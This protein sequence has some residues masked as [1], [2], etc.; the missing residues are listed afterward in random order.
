MSAESYFKEASRILEQVVSTQMGK[1][2]EAAQVLA[3][4]VANGQSIFSFGAS[5]SFILTEEIVYRAGGLMLVNPIYPHG[6]NLFIRPLTLTSRLERT[7][8]LGV[9]LLQSS[10]ARPG[11]VLIIAS[12]S[13][14]NAV[15]VD[16]ALTAVEKKIRTIGIT[17][18]AYSARVE[19]RHPS[20]KKINDLCDII[21]DNGAP[22]G[23]AVVEIPGFPQKTGPVSSFTGI[24]IVNAMVSE[25]VAILASRGIRPPVFMSANVDG[26]D[27]YNTRL[28][29]ENKDRIHYLD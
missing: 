24:A 3:N 11:D 20:G 27:D 17:S 28:L 26:G 19:S 18:L 10:P 22:C 6:M 13:G 14:R 9:E 8:G 23:D 29:K 25:T 4:A 15:V 12:T 16:M 5:H 21:I 7:P 2:K 1:I